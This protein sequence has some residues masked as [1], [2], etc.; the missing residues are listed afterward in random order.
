MLDTTEFKEY[1]KQLKTLKNSLTKESTKSGQIRKR[2]IISIAEE[3]SKRWF[4]QIK[5]KLISCGFTEDQLVNYNERFAHLLKLS[6][7]TGNLKNN[8]LEDL[9]NILQS[10]ND[11]I[12]LTLHTG[13]NSS[14]PL[15]DAYANL[16]AEV[17]DQEQSIYLK[18]AIDCAK[19]NLLKASIVLG[20]CAAIHQIHKKIEQLG[21]SKFNVA[22]AQMASAQF[23]RFKKYNKTFVVSSLDDLA[24]VFDS[25]ILW[26]IEGMG[27]VDLNQHIRLK[28][29]FDMRNHC[30][31]PGEAPITPYNVMSFFSDIN[32]ILLK[33]PKFQ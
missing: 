7:S 22:S 33:N 18:E 30:A 31:H 32:E 23:G 16:L 11:D 8:F 26:I 14:S 13:H 25:D 6:S 29:C 5:P 20:W 4:D 3:L 9:K 19:L 28:S 21:F 27:L 15:G 12:I 24:E 1:L 2:S 10:F 17:Q